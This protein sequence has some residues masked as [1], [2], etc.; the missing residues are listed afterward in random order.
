MLKLLKKQLVFLMISASRAA[1]ARMWPAWYYSIGMRATGEFD[2]RARAARV[3][4]WDRNVEKVLVS[5]ESAEAR[6]DTLQIFG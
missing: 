3:A 1:A 4:S 5:Y 6:N 2:T